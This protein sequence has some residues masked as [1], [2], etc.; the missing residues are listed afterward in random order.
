M[1]V[2]LNSKHTNSEVK[3][4]PPTSAPVPFLRAVPA[5]SMVSVL[6]SRDSTHGDLWA[7]LRLSVDLDGKNDI[8]LSM[9]LKER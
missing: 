5:T 8:S 7:Q 3:R 4:P 9:P 2:V 6:Q 1:H